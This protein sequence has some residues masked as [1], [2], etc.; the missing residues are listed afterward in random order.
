M[1]LPLVPCSFVA[2]MI[3]HPATGSALSQLISAAIM[4][5]FVCCRKI[6]SKSSIAAICFDKVSY[7]WA[8]SKEIYHVAFSTLI[9]LLLSAV[10]FCSCI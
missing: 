6:L 7:C 4:C 10:D 2:F 3:R 9:C 5:S 1:L 8:Q